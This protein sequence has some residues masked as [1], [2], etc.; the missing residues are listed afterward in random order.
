MLV[1]DEYLRN[2]APIAA[3]NHFLAQLRVVL[4]IDFA[5]LHLLLSQKTSGSLAVRTPVRD[6]QRHGGLSPFALPFPPRPTLSPGRFSLSPTFKPPVPMQ[7]L[8][9]TRLLNVPA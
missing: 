1:A 4:H 9:N 7:T 5:E 6:V 3:R 8:C 2:R